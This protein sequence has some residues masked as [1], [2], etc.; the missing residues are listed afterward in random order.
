MLDAQIKTGLRLMQASDLR[1]VLEWRNHPK[2]RKYML[3]MHEITPAEHEKWFATASL[4]VHRKLFVFERNDTA[5]GFVSFNALFSGGGGVDWGFYIAPD[6]PKGTG[7][8]LGIEALRMAFG[9]LQYHKV[10]GQALSYNDR[11]ISFHQSLG[12]KQ[13]GILREQYF[14]GERYHDLYCFGM[15]QS[16]WINQTSKA[17]QPESI[18]KLS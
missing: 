5:S 17:K 8:L 13:E 4:Q 16:E 9:Q 6:A 7:Y 14:D 1:Q 10:C 12:F 18:E 2:I 3:T 11:S 15:V